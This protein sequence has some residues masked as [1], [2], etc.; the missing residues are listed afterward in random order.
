MGVHLRPFTRNLSL[1]I[2]IPVIGLGQSQN[3]TDNPVDGFD[4]ALVLYKNQQYMEAYRQFSILAEKFP[5][6]RRNSIF[7]FMGAKS[8]YL[9]GNY[10]GA[11]TLW[12]KFILNFAGSRYLAEARLFKGH[13]LFKTGSLPGAANE[14]LLAADIDPKSDAARVARENLMPLAHRGLSMAELGKLISDNPGSSGAEV[15]EFTLAKREIESGHY[16]Q[17]VRAL[18]SFLDRHPGTRDFKQAKLLLENAAE[19]SEANMAIGLLAPFTGEYQDYGRSMIEGAKL[20]LKGEGSETLRVELLTRDTAGNP[21]LAAKIAAALSEEEPIAVVGPLRSESSISAAVVLNER[22]I[23]MITPTASETGLASIGPF[24]YQLSP[25]TEKI[26]QALARYA[27]RNLGIKEFAIISPDEAGGTKI[28]N[29]FAEAIY[30][31]GGEVIFTSYYS[32]GSTDF[33]PQ[34]MPVREILLARLVELLSSGTIDSSKFLDPKT[35]NPMPQ[36]DWPVELGGLFL[37]GYVDDLKLLIPQVRYHVIH[38]RFLGSENWG[39]AELINEVKRYIDDAVYATD[40][41]VDAADGKWQG[42]AE[43]FEASYGHPPDKVAA[44][45]YDA[46]ELILRGI[47]EGNRN[48]DDMRQYLSSIEDYEGVSG[49]IT[50]RGTGRA[51]DNVTVYSIDGRKLAGPR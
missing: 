27:V 4:N 41:H 12:E 40:F 24:I 3:P 38:T 34:I 23:P 48:C 16:R 47:K 26:G 8:L 31:L 2:L 21:I 50:F 20:A 36:D 44:L 45:T 43:K 17:G 19:K 9:A 13:A 33:K 11:I 46:V 14:Y 22:G 15:L 29:A 35:H 28:S 37:P 42:F 6:D 18:K 10:D 32:P 49:A 7:N 51:N 1:L 30:E 39:S 25:S 5:D